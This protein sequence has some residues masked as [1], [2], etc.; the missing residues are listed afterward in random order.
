MPVHAELDLAALD[1][2]DGLGHVHG[3]GAG[4]RVRHQAARAEDT[5][6]PA[7]LAHHVGGGD[8]GVEIEVAAGDLLDEIVDADL[9]G[10]RCDR[11]FCLLTGGEDEDPSRLASAVG[12]I[13]RA[14]HHLIRLAGIDA[15]T[16]RHLD[17][18]VELGRSHFLDQLHRRLGRVQLGAAALLGGGLVGLAVFHLLVPFFVVSL[19]G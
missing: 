10:A 13:D 14:A 16:H 3:D 11:G 18:L 17:G 8:D 7:D 15:E 5:A 6:Q 9:V 4:L 1:V 2:G 12:K 19:A